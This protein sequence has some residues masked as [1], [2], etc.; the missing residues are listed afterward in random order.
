MRRARKTLR[1]LSRSAIT[2]LPI[3]LFLFIRAAEL[4]G[5]PSLTQEFRRV[6]I[7]VAEARGYGPAPSFLTPIA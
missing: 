1:I 5:A 7:E 6:L 3:S 4:F 2:S